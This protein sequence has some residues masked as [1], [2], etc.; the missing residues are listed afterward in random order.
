MTWCSVDLM[1]PPEVH[2]CLWPVSES[3]LGFTPFKN[4]LDIG[5]WFNPPPSYMSSKNVHYPSKE[6]CMNLTSAMQISIRFKTSYQER[7]EADT[8]GIA[9][10]FLARI[11]K[12]RFESR[13]GHRQSL[14]DSW[15]SSFPPRKCWNSAS[16]RQRPPILSEVNILLLVN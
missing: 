10:K 14:G 7:W 5:R 13:L 15:F 1:S 11:R 16:S 12:F 4:S 8:T 9:L 6:T 3:Y 2:A